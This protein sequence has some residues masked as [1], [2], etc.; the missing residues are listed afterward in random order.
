MMGEQK[1]AGAALFSHG[2]PLRLARLRPALG[3]RSSAWEAQPR[4]PASRPSLQCC[5]LPP[6][7][8]LPPEHLDH[9]Q[10]LPSPQLLVLHSLSQPSWVWGLCSPGLPVGTDIPSS[11]GAHGPCLCRR[12]SEAPV[13]LETG[14]TGLWVPFIGSRQQLGASTR[15]QRRRE[16]PPGQPLSP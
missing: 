11:T 13:R 9:L 5:L 14:G 1:P 6:P 15:N 12:G 3:A 7:V 16:E 8:R 10:A 4:R 2:H